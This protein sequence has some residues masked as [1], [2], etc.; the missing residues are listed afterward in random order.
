MLS[1]LLL[2]L[3]CA[4][5]I[6]YPTPEPA[7]LDF[8][9]TGSME[10]VENMIST[11]QADMS[12]RTL[13]QDA[14]DWRHYR[15]NPTQHYMPN[16]FMGIDSRTVDPYLVLR[17][18][19]VVIEELESAIASATT[20]TPAA[21]AHWCSISGYLRSLLDESGL[22]IHIM[23]TLACQLNVFAAE[24]LHKTRTLLAAPYA[25]PPDLRQ[26]INTFIVRAEG[27]TL[28]KGVSSLYSPGQKEAIFKIIKDYEKRS[29]KKQEQ[30]ESLLNHCPSIG[31]SISEVIAFSTTHAT[32]LA[33]K[34]WLS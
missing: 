23:R 3:C 24:V 26:E 15:F 10:R 6:A 18:Q 7:P 31:H 12:W 34:Q 14:Q 4:F 9:T 11:I 29:A 2:S 1:F 28:K 8:S 32:I 30:L 22:R 21:V 27:D 17:Q 33:F 5:S 20:A 16:R 13:A 19:E 25:I